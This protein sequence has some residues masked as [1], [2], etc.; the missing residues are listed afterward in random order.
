MT[1]SKALRRS[2]ALIL[3]GTLTC[4]LN[5]GFAFNMGNMMNPSKWMGGGGNRNSDYDEGPWGGPGYGYGGPGYGG[6]GGPG[7]GGYGG[8]GYGG[9]GGPGYGGPGGYGAPGY[10]YGGGYPGGYDAG[11][12]GAYGV[13]S[14]VPAPTTSMPIYGT[15][16]AAS[17]GGQSELEQL[18]ERVRMLEG[19][20]VR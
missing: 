8:P 7:Y 15:P 14:P 3:G 16:S 19:A 20:G 13:S 17:T 2:L 5:T 11:A 1:N 18:R 10:G 9:Y 6:Y 12:P 4:A